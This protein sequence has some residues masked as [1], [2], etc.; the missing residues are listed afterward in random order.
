MRDELKKAVRD[1]IERFER[2]FDTDWERTKRNLSDPRSG[3]CYITDAGTFLRP[4]GPEGDPENLWRWENRDTLLDAYKKL[5]ALLGSRA[6][7]AT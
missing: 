7:D 4:V 5:K 3:E 1:F 6:N 2:V